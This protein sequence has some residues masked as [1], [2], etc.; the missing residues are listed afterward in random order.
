MSPWSSS[1]MARKKK[2]AVTATNGKLPALV[3]LTDKQAKFVRYMGEGMLGKD[4]YRAAY[5]ANG[6]DATALAQAY[7]LKRTPHIAMAIKETLRAKRLQDMDSV[8]ELIADTKQDQENARERGS[9][10]AVAAFARMRGNWLGVERNQ[11]VFAAESLLSDKELIDRLAGDDPARISAAHTLLGVTD[12]FPDA[13]D[14]DFEDV[15][16]G[17]MGND[18]TQVIDTKE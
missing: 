6:E 17:V 4:A 3:T 14:V 1:N 16:D 18:M 8:G 7:K 15:I 12:R 2:N 9:D 5:N 11:V 10:A 13:Q